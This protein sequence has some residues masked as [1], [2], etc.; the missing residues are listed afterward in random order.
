M[1]A[2]V[3]LAA[4]LVST[5]CMGLLDHRFRL[6][7][8]K[9]PC[10]TLLLVTVGVAFFLLWDLVAI[11]SGH[12]VAGESPLMSGIMVAPELPIEELVFVTFLSYITLVLWGLVDVALA[13]LAQ[14]EAR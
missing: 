11:S 8:W 2:A 1:S 3:Y 6:A 13:R 7:L 14:R 9:A 4:L 12:Y 10:R 5:F